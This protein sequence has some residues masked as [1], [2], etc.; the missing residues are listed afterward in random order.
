VPQSLIDKANQDRR[1][2]NE[3]LPYV[4]MERLCSTFFPSPDANHW[5]CL[6]AE[7]Y[8]ESRS[9]LIQI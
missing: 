8:L 7:Q 2:F 9:T 1:L 4:E 6:A 5:V 3:I